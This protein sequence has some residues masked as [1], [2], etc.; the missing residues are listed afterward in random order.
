[1][2]EEEKTTVIHFVLPTRK[3][4]AYVRAAQQKGQK[5]VPWIIQVLDNA[6]GQAEAMSADVATLQGSTLPVEKGKY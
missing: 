1:M 4:N 6:S 3:K 2:S 5:L